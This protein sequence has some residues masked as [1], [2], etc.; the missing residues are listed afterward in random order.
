MF[1]EMQRLH[2]LDLV[3]EGYGWNEVA[4]IIGCSEYSLRRWHACY[5][6]SGS[7]WQNPALRNRHDDAAVRNEDL[8]DAILTLV[9]AEPVAFLRDHVDL[10]VRLSLHF[11][12]VDHRYVSAST[13]HRVLRHNG[14]TRK[15]VERLFLERSEA[16]QRELAEVLNEVPMRCL[17]SV[18]ETHTDGGDVFRRYGRSINGVRCELL[19]RDPRSVPSTSTMMGVSMTRGVIWSQTVVLPP[20]QTADDWRLFLQCLGEQ[21]NTYVPGLPWDVQPDACVVLYDNAGIHDLHADEFMNANGM[22]HIRLSAYSP[23][24]MPIEGVFSELKKHVRELV[25]HN[26]NYLDKPRQLM[27]AAVSLLTLQQIAG[28]FTRVSHKLAEL[29]N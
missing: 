13:V 27:A 22:Y 18:D 14:Y 4:L 26:A 7:V 25:Y 2:G 20:A 1:S 17:V 21:M 16:A 24:L 5:M 29:L 11:P 19:D 8:R 6:E 10:L 28:Q 23:N 9:E 15:K 12:D 3:E